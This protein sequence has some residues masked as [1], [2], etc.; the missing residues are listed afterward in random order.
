MI[1]SISYHYYS[2]G[3]CHGGNVELWELMLDK[4]SVF[5]AQ[6]MQPFVT[7]CLESK[8][9]FRV[10]VGGTAPLRGRY[11]ATLGLNFAKSVAICGVVR[12]I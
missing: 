3:G 10:G 4:A 6:Y 7:A 5:P 8:V 1:S 2:I 11:T 9:K 12:T